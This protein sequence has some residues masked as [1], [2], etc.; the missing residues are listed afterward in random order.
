MAVISFCASG[1]RLSSFRDTL[2]FRGIACK[3][4]QIRGNAFFAEIS[5]RD[6]GRLSALAGEYGISL[7]I[8]KRRGLRYPL[9]P[10]RRRYGFAAGLL[11]GLLLLY[12]CSATVREI[13]VTGNARVSE[14]ELRQALSALGVTEGVPFRGLRYDW[15]EQRMRLAVSDIEWI[16]IR[17][18]GGRL[19]VDLTEER[20]PPPMQTGRTPCNYVAAVP[21]EVTGMNVLNGYAKVSPGDIVKPGDLLIS[22]VQTDERGVSKWCRAAGSVTGRYPAV[23]TQE[24]PFAA[25]I[26]VHSET[27]TQTLLTVLGRRI[28]LSIGFQLPDAPLLRCDE[29]S[30]PLTL[31]G[32][33]LPVSLVHRKYTVQETAV[34]VFSEAEAR[35]ILAEAAA[36]FEQNFHANDMIISRDA[37][38]RRTDLG[39]LLKINY[40]FEGVIG[41]TS[42]IF[43]K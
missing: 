10:Y 43:V 34:T 30:T 38:Y 8:L 11:C 39:I 17:K 40:V 23:F 5:A 15:L 9:L 6:E 42:E 3:N 29:Y 4:Q 26:P 7:N 41:K 1:E 12:T 35:A 25:E 32:K 16:T 2:R 36:R 21:A 31:F 33:V 37:K 18:E 13:S 28:P 19:I 24:Q 20:N 14:T 22:G 27:R